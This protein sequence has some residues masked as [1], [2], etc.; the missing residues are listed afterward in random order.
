MLDI[1]QLRTDPQGVSANLARRGFEL[2]LQQ[3]S[4]L[5]ASRKEA[6][7]AVDALALPAE[8]QA[9]PVARGVDIVVTCNALLEWRQQ[10]AAD[11]GVVQRSEAILHVRQRRNEFRGRLLAIEIAEKLR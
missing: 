9:A 3:F 1:R 8:H 10:L 2:D 6:Q 5:E 7:I 11:D 4:A